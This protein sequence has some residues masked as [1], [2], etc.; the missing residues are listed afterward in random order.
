MVIKK[1][2]RQKILEIT[3]WKIVFTTKNPDFK[4]LVKKYEIN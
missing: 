2:E 1:E 4:Y 3:N